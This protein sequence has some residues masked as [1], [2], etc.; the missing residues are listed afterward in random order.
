MCVCVCILDHECFAF[1]LL[2]DVFE[3]LTCWLNLCLSILLV[4][5]ISMCFSSLK[6]LFFIKLDSFSTDVYPSRPLD[7][8]SQ[9][10]LSHL[11]SIEKLCL[12][13]R[14]STVSR[15]IEVSGLLLDTSSTD[16]SIY[17]DPFAIDT[18]LFVLSSLM[19]FMHLDLGFHSF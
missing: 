14:F 8:F 3:S 9:Q 13:D 11:W 15:S 19:H 4:A 12:A 5:F 10:I 2:R 1:F 16:T 6:K 7:F 18:Y 17:Q